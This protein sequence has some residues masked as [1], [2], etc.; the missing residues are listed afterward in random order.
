MLRSSNFRSVRVDCGEDKRCCCCDLIELIVIQR[1]EGVYEAEDV[2][3]S[4]R[5]MTQKQN[6]D[7]PN[8]DEQK[9][10]LTIHLQCS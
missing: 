3:G 5:S 6:G 1:E 9:V 7:R 10:R 4:A 8:I 2:L